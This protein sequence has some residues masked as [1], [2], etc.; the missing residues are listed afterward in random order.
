MINT[1]LREAIR[2]T[3]VKV[4]TA[5]RA[6]PSLGRHFPQMRSMT[7]VFRQLSECLWKVADEKRLDLSD[8]YEMPFGDYSETD[9]LGEF[10]LALDASMCL[11]SVTEV[12]VRTVPSFGAI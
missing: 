9:D 5:F 11:P 12:Y 10:Y 6:V 4:Y 8:L 3:V 1:G 2:Q 7:A